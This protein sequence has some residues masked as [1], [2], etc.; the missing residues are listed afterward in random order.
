MIPAP[1]HLVVV[2]VCLEAVKRRNRRPLQVKLRPRF[3]LFT[4]LAIGQGSLR[5]FQKRV[6]RRGILHSARAIEL[7]ADDTNLLGPVLNLLQGEQLL[8]CGSGLLILIH[9]RV[10][11]VANFMRIIVFI[12]RQVLHI[13]NLV[14]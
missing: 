12:D 3:G 9:A 13:S 7:R 4:W 10:I 2:V 6:Q 1:I 11:D 8:R 5:S 14:H